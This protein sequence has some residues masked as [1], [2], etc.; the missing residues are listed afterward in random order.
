M[1]GGVSYT[2]TWREMLFLSSSGVYC[3][4]KTHF[5]LNVGSANASLLLR[6]KKTS[7]TCSPD[8]RFTFDDHPYQTLRR[9][10]PQMMVMDNA[11]VHLRCGYCRRA[12]SNSIITSE[13]DVCRVPSETKGNVGVHGRVEGLPGRQRA[14]AFRLQVDRAMDDLQGEASDA[15]ESERFRLNRVPKGA[16]DKARD[17][18]ETRVRDV[19][20]QDSTNVRVG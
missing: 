19:P 2:N 16:L 17:R 7:S 9:V 6:T 15:F 8:R 1:H 4:R 12:Q 20:R 14:E 11:T 13:L 5:S 18:V 3:E 10:S